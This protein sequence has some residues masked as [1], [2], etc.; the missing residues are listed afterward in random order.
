MPSPFLRPD[1]VAFGHMLTDAAVGILSEAGATA[2]SSRALAATLGITPSALSQRA[3]RTEVLRVVFV[4]FAD[5]WEA[6]THDLGPSAVPARLPETEDEV[7]GV[8]AWHALD[9]LARGELAQ[10]NDVP[11]AVLALARERESELVARR[12]TGLLG[13]RPADA[14][15]AVV[16]ALVGGLRREVTTTP[17]PS[18]STAMATELLTGHVASL[19]ARLPQSVRSQSVRSQSVRSA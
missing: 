19:A 6:W 8:R 1:S 17:E 13:A 10:G 11:A 15:L 5:R 16:M 4:F 3:G 2:F 12:L 18:I 7:L 14:D 9:E